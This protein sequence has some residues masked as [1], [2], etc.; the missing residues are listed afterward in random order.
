MTVSS[1]RKYK[2]KVSYHLN[3]ISFWKENLKAGICNLKLNTDF[4]FQAVKLKRSKESLYSTL[5]F[6]IILPGRSFTPII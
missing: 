1:F 6:G 2:L 5:E 4:E 3:D